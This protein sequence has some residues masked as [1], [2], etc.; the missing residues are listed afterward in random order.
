M[1]PIKFIWGARAIKNKL[2]FKKI[3]KFTYMG[4]PCFIEGAKKIKIGSKTRIFPGIRME[5]IGKGSIEIGNNVAIEQNCH[6]TSSEGHL[7]IGNN[8]TVLANTFITNIDHDYRDI[9]KHV[10]EQNTIYKETVISDGCFIGF[11]AAI[12]A[13]TKLGK[14]CVVGT[15][16]VVRGEYPDYC[17]IVGVPAKII[18]KYNLEKKSWEKYEN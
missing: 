7:K 17:V 6:I 1:H 12:Q 5:A 8:V 18:K 3:G 16:A 2:F 14:H 10:L 9:N 15:N 11:G 4:K 13:G